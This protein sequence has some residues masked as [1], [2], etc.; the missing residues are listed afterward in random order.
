MVVLRRW[1]ALQ[2]NLVLSTELI[3]RI[4]HRKEIRKLTFLA[5]VPRISRGHFFLAVFFRVTHDGLSEKGTTTRNLLVVNGII[6]DLANGICCEVKYAC[7]HANIETFRLL[8]N[9]HVCSVMKKRKK[10]QR[11]SI[12]MAQIR[13]KIWHQDKN[14]SAID[15]F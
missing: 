15:S 1:G 4:D 5:L 13:V 2:D 6:T 11:A 14:I 12:A 7:E 8:L 3:M 9:L 10:L